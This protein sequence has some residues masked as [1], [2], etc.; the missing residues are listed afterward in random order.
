[1]QETQETGDMSLIS[2]SG[3]SPGGGNSNPLQYSCLGNLVDRG[4]WWLQ[5]MGSQSQTG[6][7]A[8]H[9]HSVA[10][11]LL[12]GKPWLGTDA[13][14]GHT[15]CPAETGPQLWLPGADPHR[16]SWHMSPAPGPWCWFCSRR[17]AAA[18]SPP[19]KGSMSS[20]CPVQASNSMM[21][22]GCLTGRV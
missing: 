13:L 19:R 11:R 5:S 10:H 9:S 17:G 2:G 18:S 1:M 15:A 16:A 7:S 6:P 14:G 12:E 20:H 21:G 22:G 3:R 4:A 8:D